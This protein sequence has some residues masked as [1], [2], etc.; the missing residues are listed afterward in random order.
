M[1]YIVTNFVYLTIVLSV[2]SF[3][4]ISKYKKFHLSKVFCFEYLIVIEYLFS[5]QIE[6]PNH[7]AKS[8][9]PIQLHFV[10]D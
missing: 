2:Y 8:Y 3:W 5:M 7:I 6:P 1:T 9:S 10:N 4:V